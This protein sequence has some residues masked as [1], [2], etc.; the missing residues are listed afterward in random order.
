[1]CVCVCFPFL[2]I[3]SNYIR[4]LWII[5]NFVS[6][7][8]S[9]HE[10]DGN[11][12][13]P[14]HADSA[15]AAVMQQQ[16]RKGTSSSGS[17]VCRFKQMVVVC[18]ITWFRWSFTLYMHLKQEFEILEGLLRDMI[19]FGGTEFMSHLELLMNCL[20]F[21]LMLHKLWT[22][23]PNSIHFRRPFFFHFEVFSFYVEM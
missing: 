23:G 5:G 2:F 18:L 19:N 14:S 16:A 9:N 11:S 21:L 10:I 3:N 8:M 13:S 17:K 7:Q 1:M 4:F 15:E 20:Y 6:R 12:L 22:L